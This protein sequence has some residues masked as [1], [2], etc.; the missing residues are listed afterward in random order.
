M[1]NERN[2]PTR[3]PVALPQAQT[4]AMRTA[5]YDCDGVDLAVAVWES[6]APRLPPVILLPGTGLTASDWDVVAADLSRDRT[7]YA[8]DLRGHGASAWPGTYSIEL[9]AHDVV[10]LLPQLVGEAGRI[11]LVGHSLGG[12]VACRVAVASPLVRRLV[13]EDVGLPR[14]RRQDTPNRPRGELA[15]DWAVV[16]QVRPE[17]DSPAPDWPDVLGA[18]AV[19]VLAIGGGPASFVPQDSVRA[20]VD[21]VQD[22]TLVTIA[23][24]HEVHA[25]EPTAYVRAVRDH[26]DA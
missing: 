1:A 21:T 3:P 10:A 5:T 19:P 9:M 26:L 18:I 16:Q 13:L 25:D 17:I 2:F 8:V 14:A 11:D 20:L 24:G 23:A 12:L 22:G 7:V 15:F 4:G 6:A